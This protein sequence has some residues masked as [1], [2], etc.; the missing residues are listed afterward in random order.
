MD[1]SNRL[2]P[3]L[4]ALSLSRSHSVK[5]AL[6]ALCLLSPTTLACDTSHL[7]LSGTLS[8]TT[9]FPKR[10]SN[11]VSS[12][13]ALYEYMEAVPDSEDVYTIGLQASP[14]R[15]YDGEMRIL[16]VEDVADAVRRK[17]DGKVQR[18]ELLGSWTG[19]SPAPGV[20]SQAERISQALG[21]LPVRGEDGFLWLAKDG[22]HRTTRQA[23]TVREGA[24][25]YSLPEGAEVFV[26]LVAGWP[27]YV[28]EQ[29]PE[30][31]ANLLMLAAAGWD[32]FFLCPDKA[33][34]GFEKAAAKG[35]AIAAYNAALMRLERGGDEDRTAAL[36][37]LERGS[38]LGD[39]KSRARLRI[40][41]TRK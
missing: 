11:C 14:W 30:E 13:K 12:G 27:A 28:Q 4:P 29:I 35:N 8:V 26:P 7:S 2:A 10:D 37:L 21:G 23:F 38:V 34:D 6:F 24:G 39:A 40:E 18:V 22:T 41:R 20:P 25:S 16:T 17:L 15:M 3:I 19:V 5:P 32:V 36:A 1:P 33:L 31:D 9:C